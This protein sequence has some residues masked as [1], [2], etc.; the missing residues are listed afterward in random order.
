MIDSHVSSYVL[1]LEMDEY[2]SED[3]QQFLGSELNKL[4]EK[5]I[6]IHMTKT[7]WEPVLQPWAD[8]I[9]YQYGFGLTPEEITQDTNLML[10]RLADYP[11]KLFIAGE[12]GFQIP[13]EESK[14]LGDAAVDA[15][16][17]GFG[18]GGSPL[19]AK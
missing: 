7:K 15:G 6:F 8:G 11:E 17:L 5:T 19:P 10:R 16:A 3:E 2:W 14:A 4:T 9:I 13:A 12:Y 18:N 1:G